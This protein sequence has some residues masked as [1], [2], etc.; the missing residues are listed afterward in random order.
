MRTGIEQLWQLSQKVRVRV[1][2]RC[3]V[4]T[5]GLGLGEKIVNDPESLP[6]LGHSV[7]FDTGYVP[8]GH[9]LPNYIYLIPKVDSICDNLA[10][11]RGNFRLNRQ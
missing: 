11:D 2:V 9:V 3:F 10:H 5:L 4:L 7:A 1:R 6:Q 8:F